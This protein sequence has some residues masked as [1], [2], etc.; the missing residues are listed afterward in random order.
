MVFA[1]PA[2][3][4][5]AVGLATDAI[6]A[7]IKKYI[8]DPQA[9]AQMEMDVFKVLQSSDLAQLEINKAEAQSGS[10]F[11]A[12]WRP[13]IGWICA[14]TLAW[15]FVVKGWAFSVISLFSDKAAT[16]I[17]NSPGIDNSVWELVFAMLGMGAL[18]S[19]D[20]FKG[21]ATR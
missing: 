15:Q 17:L 20:K 10:I 19:F 7:V 5:T 16:A 13:A 11:V 6:S 21:V 1:L 8:P 18:R 9:Q 3:A 2:L 4:G 14:T 12:G